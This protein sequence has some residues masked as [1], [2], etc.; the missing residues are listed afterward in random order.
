MEG[1]FHCICSS[2]N[3]LLKLIYN[4]YITDD[5]YRVFIYCLPYCHAFLALKQKSF[6]KI[7]LYFIASSTLIIN[8]SFEFFNKQISAQFIFVTNKQ[9]TFGIIEVEIK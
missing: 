4:S 3:M 7:Y 5:V 2:V 9:N 6:T 8:A 1:N